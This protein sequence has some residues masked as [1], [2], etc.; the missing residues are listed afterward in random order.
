MF[1]H[2]ELEY[3]YYLV[4]KKETKLVA[5]T[6]LQDLDWD[7]DNEVL[8]YAPSETHARA[9]FN[10]FNN[11][12]LPYENNAHDALA[13]CW[14]RIMDSKTEKRIFYKELVKARKIS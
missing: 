5:Q 8:T 13:V 3:N 9:L 14:P 12:F 11:G 4:S 6:Y 1:L 10:L 7:F 2:N